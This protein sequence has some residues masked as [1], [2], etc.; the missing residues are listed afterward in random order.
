MPGP[1]GRTKPEPKL[2]SSEA[3]GHTGKTRQTGM[4]AN[5][6]TRQAIKQVK[7]RLRKPQKLQED[8][9]E[10]EAKIRRWPTGK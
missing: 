7:K 9:N 5:G 2:E 1:R 10:G 8:E 4:K 3:Q 6:E